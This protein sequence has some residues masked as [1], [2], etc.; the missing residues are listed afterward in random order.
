MKVILIMAKGDQSQTPVGIA[1]SMEQAEM[2]LGKISLQGS[3]YMYEYQLYEVEV[4]ID[5]CWAFDGPVGQRV[6]HLKEQLPD[7]E[8]LSR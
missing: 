8:K 6:I 5:H 2:L 4:D 7:M 3:S 1:S